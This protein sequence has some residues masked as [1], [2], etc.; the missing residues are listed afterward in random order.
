M[1]DFD[2]G[3]RLSLV[4]LPCRLV[5][6]AAARRVWSRGVGSSSIIGEVLVWFPRRRG[7]S[8]LQCVIRQIAFPSPPFSVVGGR[9]GQ[10]RW[11]GSGPRRRNGRGWRGGHR[12]CVSLAGGEGEGLLESC[13][14]M[15]LLSM[16][17]PCG[18][19]GIGEESRSVILCER[20]HTWGRREGV[21]LGASARVT[22]LVGQVI[23]YKDSLGQGQRSIPTIRSWG[24]PL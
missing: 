4:L 5:S 1:F 8:G 13:W 11:R 20:G 19:G 22:K 12:L 18:L 17:E 21:G 15:R 6:A 14:V 16:E 23:D 10:I 3:S 24:F 9:S 7:L 2:S